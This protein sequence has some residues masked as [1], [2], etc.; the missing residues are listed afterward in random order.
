MDKRVVAGELPR[1]DE[2]HHLYIHAV[3]TMLSRLPSIF[4]ITKRIIGVMIWLL[5]ETLV[6]EA[7]GLCT[8]SNRD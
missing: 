8:D 6:G 7:G 4:L 5:C 2:M 1:F 3:F